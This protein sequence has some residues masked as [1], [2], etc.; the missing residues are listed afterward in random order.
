[1]IHP[2]AAIS[3]R[4]KAED[5]MSRVQTVVKHYPYYIRQLSR[6]PFGAYRRLTRARC[7]A[8]PIMEP[9]LA[10]KTGLEIGGP[11]PFY[12][13]NGMVPVYELCQEIDNCNF[14]ARTLWTNPGGQAGPRVKFHREIVAEACDLSVISD[15][16]YD[17]VVAS[18]V[19][20][21]IANPLRA[22]REWRRVLKAN[23][24]LL[25]VVPDKRNTFDRKRPFTSFEHIAAD[26]ANGTDEGDLTHLDEILFLH[27]LSLD[28]LAGSRQQFQE[29]C[30]QNASIRAIHHH[31]FSQ[32]VLNHMIESVDMQVLSLRCERPIHITGFAQK[33]T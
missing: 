10:G 13:A 22:L 28:P 32:R 6:L 14:A 5:L 8:F 17:F 33:L 11:S 9:F 15:E 29:R 20:E 21:H 25:I 2:R 7:Q 3:T 16:T 12:C 26:F 19:L 27:D 31:V 30:L 24:V 23:G 1:M 18:H 4:L